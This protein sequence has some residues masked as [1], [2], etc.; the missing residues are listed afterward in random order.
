[1]VLQSVRQAVREMHGYTPGEQPKQGRKIV[2]LNTNENPYPVPEVITEAVQ[3]CLA[4][5]LRK[6]PE[7][8]S[9]PVRNAAAKAYGLHED[10][11]L[12]GN[13]SD[14]IL[15]IILRTFINE[16]DVVTTA[17]PTY[18][19]YG[20]LT[21]LQGGRYQPVPW[22]EDMSLP[23]DAL[24]ATKAKVTFVVRP[25]S[26]TGHAVPLKDVAEL[27][28]RTKGA[29]ILDEA[30]ADFCEDNGISLLTDHPNLVVTRTFSKSFSL[31]AM[32]IGLG[33]MSPE[34]AAQMHKVRD[35]YNV[36]ALAQA[37]AVAALDSLDAFAPYIARI[38]ASREHL[39]EALRK[40]GFDVPPS[41]ANFVLATIPQGK[42]TGTDWLNDLRKEGYLVRYF[43]NIPELAGKLRISV[44]SEEE[45]E[46]LLAA[47]DRLL[48]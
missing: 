10:Q 46:G 24:V 30:Y 17:A 23:I 33:F 19:L 38:K 48:D 42:R 36:D 26:P 11:I 9:W 37:A 5:G 29:V 8:S 16:G 32:R 35:S 47:I 7:P 43:G 14:D 20:T 34:L 31:A 1:M 40:R 44:G 27:C 22:G 21:Q 6:Y 25:N 3:E 18:S 28:Q 13:G 15:T 41:H 45:C 12:I 4:Q 39:I 2:K